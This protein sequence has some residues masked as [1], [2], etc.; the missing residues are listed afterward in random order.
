MSKEQ[1]K[2]DKT[3]NN[4]RSEIKKLSWNMSIEVKLIYNNFGMRKK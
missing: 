4:K 1:P 2:S 3:E